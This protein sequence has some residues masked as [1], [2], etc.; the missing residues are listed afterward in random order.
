[1]VVRQAVRQTSPSGILCF[2][3]R[4]S[5]QRH[6]TSKDSALYKWKTFCGHFVALPSL[7]T[8]LWYLENSPRLPLNGILPIR[9]HSPQA[10]SLFRDSLWLVVQQINPES[11][12]WA[13]SLQKCHT[14]LIMC[15]EC[16]PMIKMFACSLA[17]YLLCSNH[18][19]SQCV[20]GM[21]KFCHS[22]CSCGVEETGRLSQ[23]THVEFPAPIS[24]SSQLL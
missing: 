8:L 9:K 3:S 17:L 19:F 5:H 23:M 16:V 22:I 20:K 7:L 24:S 4:N 6:I 10:A 15:L 14:S 1:M 11:H 13:M 2:S 21:I 18:S 12:C